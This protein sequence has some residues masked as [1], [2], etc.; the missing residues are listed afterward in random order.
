[1]SN[2]SD[3]FGFVSFHKAVTGCAIKEKFKIQNNVIYGE[4]AFTIDLSGKVLIIFYTY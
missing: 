3:G 4:Q 2:A 1:M